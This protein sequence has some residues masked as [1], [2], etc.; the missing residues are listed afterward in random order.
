MTRR[1]HIGGQVRVAGWE[2]LNANP[3]PYVDHVCNAANLSQFSDNTF[4]DIYASHVVEHFDFIGELPSTL[5]EW[6]RVLRPGGKIYISVPDL[7]VLAQLFLQKKELSAAERFSVMQMMFGAHIDQYDHHKVGLNEE[8]LANYLH[9]C[10]Y[11]NMRRVKHFGLFDDT[12]N[13]IYKGVAIS[14][15]MVAEK[16]KKIKNQGGSSTSSS[17][18]TIVWVDH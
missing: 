10:G 3:A 6:C 5:K 13:Y 16:P 12:S 15:N 7:D 14:L 9:Y 1:L 17:S 8:I 18:A 11:V 2:V 4:S